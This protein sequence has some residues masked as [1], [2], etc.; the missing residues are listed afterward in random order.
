MGSTPV[1]QNGELSPSGRISSTSLGKVIPGR[2]ISKDTE[3]PIQ[4]VVPAV[5]LPS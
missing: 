1:L 5:A 2:L 3:R 4:A